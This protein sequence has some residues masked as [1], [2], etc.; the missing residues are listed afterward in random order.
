MNAADG[1]ITIDST[2]LDFDQTV[3]AVASFVRSSM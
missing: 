1:V 3:T 2:N